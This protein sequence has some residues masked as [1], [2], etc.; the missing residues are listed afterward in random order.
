MTSLLTPDSW[1]AQGYRRAQTSSEPSSHA[2]ISARP[3][4]TPRWSPLERFP[5]GRGCGGWS[6]KRKQRGGGLPSRRP[7]RSRPCGR[8]SSTP[9]GRSRPHDS[10][11]WPVMWSNTRSRLPTSTCWPWSALGCSRRRRWSSRTPETDSMPLVRP[12]FRA[13]SPSTTTPATTTSAPPRWSCRVWVIPTASTRASLPTTAAP[14]SVTGSTLRR[15]RPWCP[16]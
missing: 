15:W 11:F 12:I 4:S 1:R 7:P 3:R 6:P 16:G 10:W 2:G 8:C 5:R 14:P 9:S 13:W